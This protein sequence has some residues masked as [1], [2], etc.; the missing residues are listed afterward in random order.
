MRWVSLLASTYV[1]LMTML[2]SES[3]FRKIRTNVTHSSHRF[4]FCQCVIVLLPPVN[5]GRCCCWFY[6]IL[7]CVKLVS[8]RIKTYIYIYEE[9][10]NTQNRRRNN[11][12]RDILN[13]H[14]T[15]WYKNNQVRRIEDRTHWIDEYVIVSS[16]T[17]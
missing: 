5:V 17:I 8:A 16:L 10:K 14:K 7:R 1:Q 15:K 11:T 12:L 9:K 4:F 3:L 2:L 6:L 13:T